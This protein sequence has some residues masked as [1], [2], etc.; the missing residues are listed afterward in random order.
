MKPFYILALLILAGITTRCK[1][2]PGTLKNVITANDS[3]TKYP[4]VFEKTVPVND[5]SDIG[6]DWKVE[7]PVAEFELAGKNKLTYR[8]ELLNDSIAALSQ[9]VKGNWQEQDKFQFE[10]WHWI[11]QDSLVISNFETKDFDKD[12]DDDV[13]CC[14]FSNINGNEWTLIYLNDGSK[15]VKLYDTADDTDQWLMPIYKE[16]TKTLHTE[17]FSSAYGVANTATYRLEG[18]TAIPLKKEEGDSATDTMVITHYTYKGEN[19]KWKL[20]KKEIEKVPEE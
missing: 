11:V 17:M 4:I 2:H 1:S 13:L 19:G 20:T 9:K 12:G 5:S 3:N 10:P 18:T 6:I 7:K 14:L 16:N 15:L 8:F